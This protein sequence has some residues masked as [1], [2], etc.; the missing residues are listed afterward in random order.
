M[1]APMNIPMCSSM[2]DCMVTL[3]VY[4]FSWCRFFC[5]TASFGTGGTMIVRAQSDPT[6]ATHLDSTQAGH[7]RGQPFLFCSNAVKRTDGRHEGVLVLWSSRCSLPLT[8]LWH[9]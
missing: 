1:F 3:L 8:V 6:G 2:A 5:T 4:F 9:C 7:N